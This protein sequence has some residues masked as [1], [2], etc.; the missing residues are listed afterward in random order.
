MDQNY[1]V[2][3]TMMDTIY[4]AFEFFCFSWGPHE[5]DNVLCVRN[6]GYTAP[7]LVRVQS[8]CYT[9][10]I[11]RS[12]DCDCHEQLD[13][14]LHMIAKMGGVLIYMLCDGRGAGLYK[15]VLGLELGRTQ[16]LDTSDAYR[17]L[18]LEQDPRHYDHA[19]AILKHFDI[20]SVRLLTNNPRKVA[21]LSE[22]GIS[23]AREALEIPSTEASRPYLL[24][25]KNKMG[26]LLSNID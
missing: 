4:G 23:V 16:G 26:H 6:G 8:A 21:G 14:S 22:H 25:K 17:A 3:T 24:T 19:A 13:R 5:E 12:L 18:G 10:E 7:V 9:A 1:K 15:K 20:R 11:F 2:S